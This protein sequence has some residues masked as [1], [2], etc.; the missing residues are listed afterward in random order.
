MIDFH[1]ERDFVSVFTSHGSEYSEC[2]CHGV[3]PALD[4][5]FY[6]ISRIKIERIRGERRSC[7]VFNS[8][9]H[10]EN[11]HV[12]GIGQATVPQDG[13]QAVQCTGISIG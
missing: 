3:T 1:Y 7:R 10:G 6:D 5:K 12:P 13:L 11:G 2:R 8:L 4:S 9:I